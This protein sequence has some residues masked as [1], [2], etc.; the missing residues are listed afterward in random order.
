MRPAPGSPGRK[1][2]NGLDNRARGERERFA[3][4]ALPSSGKAAMRPDKISPR[5]HA[6]AILGRCATEVFRENK[7]EF[8][9]DPQSPQVK[10]LEEAWFYLRRAMTRLQGMA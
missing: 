1:A 7:R 8:D 9:R 3:K 10:R 5:S 6:I 2:C 4:G